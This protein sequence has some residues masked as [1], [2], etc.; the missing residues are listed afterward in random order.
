[1]F[2]ETQESEQ[3]QHKRQHKQ[4]VLW[5]RYYRCH[6]ATIRQQENGDDSEDEEEELYDEEGIKKRPVQKK[7]K[8]AG[9]LAGLKVTCYMNDMDNVVIS[10]LHEHDGHIPRSIEDVQFLPKS[11]MLNERI[12]EE[13]H[14]GYNVRSVREYLQRAY[15]SLPITNRDSYVNTVDVYNIFYKY[16]QERCAKDTDDFASVKKWLHKFQDEGYH[17]WVD[18][19][20]SGDVTVE[21]LSQE[22]FSFGF[23]AP[24]Q[25][26]L[27]LSTAGKFISLDATHDAS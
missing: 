8:Q 20:N 9:C 17:V 4:T 12:L 24:W 7:T 13:L 23:C 19:D 1:M 27:L 25:K 14:K 6:R 18:N 21:L 3:H 26:Q 5:T 22:R 15:D 2:I 10:Y 11:D 16:R